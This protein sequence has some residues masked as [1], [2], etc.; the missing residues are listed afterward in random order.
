MVKKR[1]KNWVIKSMFLRSQNSDVDIFDLIFPFLFFLL[2]NVD[3]GLNRKK[4]IADFI[5]LNEMRRI[6]LKKKKVF[7]RF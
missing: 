6:K 7:V 1:T 5:N 4:Y 2:L 3:T